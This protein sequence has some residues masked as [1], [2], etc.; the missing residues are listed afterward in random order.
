MT[1]V[2]FISYHRLPK[3]AT[4]PPLENPPPPIR[5]TFTSLH[6][7][8]A[9]ILYVIM[10]LQRFAG[11]IFFWNISQPIYIGRPADFK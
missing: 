9:L 1:S 6:D 5:G 8:A 2:H 11:F 4:R 3:F 7:L 10:L